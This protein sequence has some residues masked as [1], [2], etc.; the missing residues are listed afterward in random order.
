M[1]T[2]PNGQGQDHTSVWPDF[3]CYRQI[4]GKDVAERL[5]ALLSG[6]I[7]SVSGHGGAAEDRPQ[8]DIYFDQTAP[9][10][11]D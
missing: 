2:E 9:G 8:L 10:V 7:V 3:V 6:R 1:L 11:A 5:V 4:D